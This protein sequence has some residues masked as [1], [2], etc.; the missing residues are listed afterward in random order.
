MGRRWRRVRRTYLALAVLVTAVA[1]VFIASVFAKPLLPSIS[2]RPGSQTTKPIK[3]EALKLPPL[4]VTRSERKAKKA[5][6][7]LKQALAKTPRV[8]PAGRAQNMPIVMAPALPPPVIPGSRPI[9]IGFYINWD[10]SS[11]ASLQRNLDH[12]DW[13]VPQWVHLQE[14]TGGAEPIG[15]ELDPAALDLI[16]ETRP[17]IRIIPMVQNLVNDQWNGDLLVRS[18]A[19]EASRQRL[20]SA[21][22]TFVGQYNFGGVCIDFEE[23][24]KTSQPNLVRFMQTLHAAFQLRNWLV[25]QAVPFDS[26]ME[27]QGIRGGQ[28]IT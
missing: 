19:D 25:M 6:D 5:Q 22:T 3:I 11:Y 27:L 17:Q 28:R 26:G 2:L 7:E 10:E 12:L 4:P 14:S 8:V 13:L 18:I 1:A 23:L 9:A 16:R 21:L 15:V 24:P 20:V